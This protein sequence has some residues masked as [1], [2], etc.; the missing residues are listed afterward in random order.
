LR[1]WDIVGDWAIRSKSFGI[2]RPAASNVT[3]SHYQIST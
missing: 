1:H 3:T 2:A